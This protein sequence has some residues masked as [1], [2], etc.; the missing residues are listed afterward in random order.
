MSS[1]FILNHF[2]DWPSMKV[3]VIFGI[4][5]CAIACLG[6]ESVPEEIMEDERRRFQ[7]LFM[8]TWQRL[9]LKFYSHMNCLKRN[10]FDVLENYISSILY[11]QTFSCDLLTWKSSVLVKKSVSLNASSEQLMLKRL[12]L[13]VLQYFF[14]INIKWIVLFWFNVLLFCIFFLALDWINI[15]IFKLE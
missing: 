5:M 2:A 7:I 1:Y 14:E 9:C 13:V 6:Q 15:E 12:F 8:I 4:L 3:Q 11:I 10:F